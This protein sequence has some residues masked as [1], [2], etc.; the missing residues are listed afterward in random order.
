MH[1]VYVLLPVG[2]PFSTGVER[3]C[4]LRVLS[5]MVRR[6]W[7]KILALCCHI[8]NPIPG[9]VAGVKPRTGHASVKR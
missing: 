2:P 1:L 8:T 7:T 3:I 5:G 6:Q 4:G 9:K